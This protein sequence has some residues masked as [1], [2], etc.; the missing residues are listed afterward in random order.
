MTDSNM[1][2]AR[3]KCVND[4]ILPKNGSKAEQDVM[5]DAHCTAQVTLRPTSAIFVVYI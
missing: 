4:T 3:M 2:S 1:G 5:S